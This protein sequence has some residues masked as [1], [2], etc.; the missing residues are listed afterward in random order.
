MTKLTIVPSEASYSVTDGIEVIS[1]KLDGGLSRSRKDKTDAAM[2]VNVKWTALTKIQF[3]YIRAF[4]KT[5]AKTGANEFTIDLL[6]DDTDL[7]EHT[8]KFVPGSFKTDSPDGV[9]YSISAQ[10]EAQPLPENED[11]NNG[12]VAVYNAYGPNAEGFF[13]LLEEFINETLP[14]LPVFGG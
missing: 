12:F 8:V 1:T 5:P 3:E 4:Y 6:I 10:L 9:A 2:L 11:Y 13:N 14:D 7:T